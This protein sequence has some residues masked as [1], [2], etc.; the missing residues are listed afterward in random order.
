LRGRLVPAGAIG[1]VVA[2]GGQRPDGRAG[3]FSTGAKHPPPPNPPPGG[4]AGAVISTLHRYAAAFSNGDAAA[5]ASVLAPTVT[6]TGVRPP[7][8]GCHTDRGRASVVAAERRNFGGT[9]SFASLSPS[10]VQINGPT[11]A[12]AT[13]YSISSGGSGAIQLVLVQQGGGWLITSI[14]AQC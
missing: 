14:S 12:V 7:A 3:V 9:Y 4:Q 6:R 10:D 2:G 5:M 13:R 1:L 8:P 11:A